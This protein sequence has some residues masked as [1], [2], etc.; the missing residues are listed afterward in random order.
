MPGKTKTA[1]KKTSKKPPAKALIKQAKKPAGKGKKKQE[2]IETIDFCGVKLTALRR[3]FLINYI[4]PGQ[5]CFHN[6]LQAAIKA[7]YKEAVAKSNI[8]SIL[9]E[10]DIQKIIKKNESIAY[11]ALHASAMRALELKQRR[12]FFDPINYFEEKEITLTNKDDEEYT[13]SIISL[14]P[15]QD[16]TPEDRMCIDGVDFKGMQGIPVYSLPDRAKEINDIIKIDRELSGNATA[17]GYDIEETKEII[18]ERVTIRQQRRMVERE[19]V[20]QYEIIEKP[21]T[22][23]EEEL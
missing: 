1:T 18:V 6:A 14:K 19:E 17:D 22:D 15:M 23:I 4:T 2:E 5:P 9:R 20:A 13:K 7:G 12:A 3:D 10:P 8:Y 11:Q 16:M 21:T